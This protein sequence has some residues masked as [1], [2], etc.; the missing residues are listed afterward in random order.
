MENKKI[1]IQSTIVYIV[2]AGIFGLLGAIIPPYFLGE[3][4]QQP[5]Y[6]PFLYWVIEN[7][8]A[9][10]GILWFFVGI[11]LG[12]KQPKIWFIWGIAVMSL[13]PILTI[14][15]VIIY[16]K[17]HNLLPFEII[18]YA[19]LSVIPFLGSLTGMIIKNLRK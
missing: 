3:L 5:D 4:K 9:T 11:F 12:Y 13:F 8:H 7:S 2:I 19:I 18:M 15:E 1:N 14:Y 16:P 17:S 6:Y 10:T